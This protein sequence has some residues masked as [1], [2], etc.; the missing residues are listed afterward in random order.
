VPRVIWNEPI[1][2][3]ALPG[4]RLRAGVW[5]AGGLEAL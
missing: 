2:F 4:D 3:T 5:L 1:H